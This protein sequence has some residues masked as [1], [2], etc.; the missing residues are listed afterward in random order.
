MRAVIYFFDWWD[1]ELMSLNWCSDFILSYVM[2]W[3]FPTLWSACQKGISF[4]SCCLGCGL[5]SRLLL[6]FIWS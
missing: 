1:F 6:I 4:K 5:L 2:T 3:P